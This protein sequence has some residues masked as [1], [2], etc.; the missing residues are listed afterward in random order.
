MAKVADDV[1][2][3]REYYASKYGE[4]LSEKTGA[5]EEAERESKG[6]IEEVATLRS[7]CE[8]LKKVCSCPKR[9]RGHTRLT[10]PIRRSLALRES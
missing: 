7:E 10:L 4:K 9:E 2:K 8:E 6:Q 1:R 5:D 3:M